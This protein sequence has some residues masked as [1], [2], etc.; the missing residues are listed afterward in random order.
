MK[1]RSC[2]ETPWPYIDYSVLRQATGSEVLIDPSAELVDLLVD[3]GFGIEWVDSTMKLQLPTEY[4]TKAAE[5]LVQD[6][7][8]AFLNWLGS[9]LYDWAL[10]TFVAFL[11]ISMAVC[12]GTFN[13]AMQSIAHSVGFVGVALIF[14]LHIQRQQNQKKKLAREASKS[15][16]L[17]KLKKK[18]GKP[19]PVD[20][21]RDEVA[22]E[23]FP[24]SKRQQQNWK[25]NAW[26]EVKKDVDKD[27]YVKTTHIKISGKPAQAWKSATSTGFAE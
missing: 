22:K 11:A 5:C 6:G 17:E 3:D 8:K 21:I 18:N 15:I 13:F 2:Q 16:V 26:P 24:R 25:K 14:M 7:V 20:I 10:N 9:K 23:L 27:S 19:I 4:R 1:G 12:Y